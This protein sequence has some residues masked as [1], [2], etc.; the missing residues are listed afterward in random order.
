MQSTGCDAA[1]LHTKLKIIAATPSSPP[2]GAAT[3]LYT[4]RALAPENVMLTEKKAMLAD[5][6]Y[7]GSGVPKTSGVSVAVPDKVAVLL[8]LADAPRL[9]EA[10]TFCVANGVFVR[11]AV[12]PEDKV[13][14][15]EAVAVSLADAPKVMLEVG[16]SETEAAADVL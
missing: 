7:V 3:S 2:L 16:V 4:S 13:A 9:N 11:D 5:G 15:R 1:A 14:V 6:A 10:V 8:T 12:A